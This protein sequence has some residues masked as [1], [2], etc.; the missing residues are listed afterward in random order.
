MSWPQALAVFQQGKAAMWIDAD[1]FYP[2]LIDPAKSTVTNSVGF[3]PFPLGPAGAKNYN[4]T[5]WA[6]G[7]NESS[8]EKAGAAWEFVKWATS[9]PVGLALQQKCVPGARPSILRPPDG[10]NAFPQAYAK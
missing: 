10:L 9:A 5:S 6:L 7:I 1:V 3:A 8:P 4:V 2:N